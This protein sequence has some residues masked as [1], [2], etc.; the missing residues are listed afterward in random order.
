[1]RVWIAVWTGSSRIAQALAAWLG[2]Q[3]LPRTAAVFGAA[4]FIKGLPWTWRIA[5][6]ATAAWL[7]TAVV[8]GLR[9]PDPKAKAGEDT[10]AEAEPPAETED[11]CQAD[12]L[13]EKVNGFGLTFREELALALHAVGAPHAHITAL[14]EHLGAPTD[15]VRE[16]LTEA[17][18]PISGGVRMKGRPVAVSPGVKQQDFPPLPSPAQQGAQEGALTSNNNDNNND[19]T[20]FDT[21]P[22]EANPARTHVRWRRASA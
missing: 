15:R 21:V 8:L 9:L 17:R 14:A 16:A 20:A 7:I 5:W 13:P 19:G 3:P 12:E 11:D 6:T 22:D 18:I 4:L 1:M 10:S 2:K